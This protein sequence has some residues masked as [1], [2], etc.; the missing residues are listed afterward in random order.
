LVSPFD[1]VLARD[2]VVQPDLLGARK[3]DF[4]ERDLPV[5]PLLAVEVLTPSTCL[6]T[7]P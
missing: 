1:V 2:T 5:P 3:S 6:S 7:S 4:S